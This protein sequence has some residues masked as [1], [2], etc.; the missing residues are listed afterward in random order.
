MAR[1][2]VLV[3]NLGE[4]KLWGKTPHCGGERKDMLGDDFL[5]V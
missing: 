3:L 5:V 2:R 1:I 4:V